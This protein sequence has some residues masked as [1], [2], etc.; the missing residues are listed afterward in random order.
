MAVMKVWKILPEGLYVDAVVAS[1]RRELSWEVDY[2]REA[3]CCKRFRN[4]LKDDPF[5][6]VPE[7]VD[8]LSD[9]FVLTTE[10]IEGFPVDQCFDLDQEIRNKIA[11]AILKLCLTELFEWRFMQTDPNWSNFFYSPQNDKV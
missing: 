6:Y 4:L 3:E 7:V 9:K 1:A 2:I 10:L 11:N 5:L 8:E